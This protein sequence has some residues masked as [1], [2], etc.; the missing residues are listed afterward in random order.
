MN[1]ECIKM[2]LSLL[3]CSRL[4]ISEQKQPKPQSEILSAPMMPSTKTH[5]F[6]RIPHNE[7]HGPRGSDD[8]PVVAFVPGKIRALNL[9]LVN[10]RHSSS[11]CSRAR[12]RRNTCS[13]ITITG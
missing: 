5:Y 13:G 12:R 10:R 2:K 1:I 3:T 8:S 4:K 6:E 9:M 11:I 7:C